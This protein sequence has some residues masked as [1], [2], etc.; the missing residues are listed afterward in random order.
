MLLV[1]RFGA[2]QSRQVGDSGDEEIKRFTK[3]TA[4]A[5]GEGNNRR[6]GEAYAGGPSIRGPAS[7]L[8]KTKGEAGLSRLSNSIKPR[9]EIPSQNR[10]CRP[11]K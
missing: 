10:S 5:T 2:F 4:E 8:A 7:S 11:F 9:T 6:R 3:A 1:S